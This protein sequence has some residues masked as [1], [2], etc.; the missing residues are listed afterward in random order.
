MLFSN[1][2]VYSHRWLRTLQLSYPANAASDVGTMTLLA[3]LDFMTL[4]QI[5]A[6]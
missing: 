1:W 2:V 4:V 6:V 3:I 5:E